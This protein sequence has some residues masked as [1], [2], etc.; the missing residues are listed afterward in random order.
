MNTPHRSR[1]LVA[2]LLTVLPGLPPIAVYWAVVARMPSVSPERAKEILAEPGADAVL[3]D[4]RTPDEFAADHLG[5][6]RNWPYGRIMTTTSVEQIP[7]PFRGKRLLLICQSGILSSLATRHLR[8]LGVFEGEN[9]EGG[10]QMWVASAQKPC[11]LGLCQ[12]RAASGAVRDLP[13]RQSSL[14]EQW[15]AVVTGFAIKPFYTLLALLVIVLLWPQKA[16]DLAALRWGLIAFF[17]GENF[18]AANYVIFAEQSVV[19]EYLHSYGMVVCFGMVVYALFEGIDQRLLHLSDP[20]SRCAAMGLCRRCMKH[21]QAPCGLK[22]LF[23]FLIPALMAIAPAP[24]CAEFVLTSYN[25]SILGS[26]YNYSH[27][28]VHQIF[29]VRYLPGVA[30]LLLTVS[31]AIL[32]AKPNGMAWSKIFFAAGTGAMGFSLF[33][34]V[35]L[36]VYRDNLVWFAAWEELTELLFV[37]GVAVVLW[38]FR[39]SLLPEFTATLTRVEVSKTQPAQ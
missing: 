20:D 10:M 27:A 38:V 15:T 28:V 24:F 19:M 35:L 32:W 1:W 8:E 22:R 33:R 7:A 5:A 31:W 39:E 34:L 26:F 12:L 11:T 29:E 21:A 6:A 3:V 36:D 23:L 30:L 13:V 9:V 16:T 37:L 25:T 17:V 2:V 4:V 18:C 14:V